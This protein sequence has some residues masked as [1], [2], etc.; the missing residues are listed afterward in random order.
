M[1]REP[2]AVEKDG[3]PSHMPAALGFHSRQLYMDLCGRRMEDFANGLKSRCD[4]GKR[5][6]SLHSLV[7]SRRF[8]QATNF[9]QNQRVKTIYINSLALYGSQELDRTLCRF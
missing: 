4:L 6:F 5:K 9:F 2:P 1:G 3:L 7:I 8:L